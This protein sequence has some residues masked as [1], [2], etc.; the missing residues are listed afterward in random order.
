MR[1]AKDGNLIPVSLTISP[2]RDQTGKIIGTSK[3]TRDIT[4][5]K[6]AEQIQLALLKN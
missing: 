5:S 4:D 1:Q 6:E 3:I 2:I